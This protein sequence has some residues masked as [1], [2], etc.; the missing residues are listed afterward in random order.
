LETSTQVGFVTGH[1]FSRAAKLQNNVGFGPC[2]GF[3]GK[4]IICTDIPYVMS[5]QNAK[6]KFQEAWPGSKI[7]AIHFGLEKLRFQFLSAEAKFRTGP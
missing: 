1:E 5:W 7:P 4:K 6:W 2:E 3:P